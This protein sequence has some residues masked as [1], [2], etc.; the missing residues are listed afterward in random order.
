MKPR[1]GRKKYKQEVIEN[2]DIMAFK[3]SIKSKFQYQAPQ[4]KKNKIN[5]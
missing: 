4:I 5:S 1:L 3:K 2:S